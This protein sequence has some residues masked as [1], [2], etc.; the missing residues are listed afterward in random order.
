MAA[1][2]ALTVRL[3]P[4]PGSAG[5]VLHVPSQ[6]V[7]PVIVAPPSVA[8]V[9]PGVSRLPAGE[10]HDLRVLHPRPGGTIVTAASPASAPCALLMTVT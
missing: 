6:G 8:L 4:A 2:V 7:P 3:I 5:R 9:P 10:S 1:V